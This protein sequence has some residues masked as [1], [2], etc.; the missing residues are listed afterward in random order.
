M[1]EI[2]II[3]HSNGSVENVAEGGQFEG[4][5]LREGNKQSELIIPHIELEESSSADDLQAWQFNLL[6]VD[7][8]Y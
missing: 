1:T 2:V 8:T 6:G 3:E 4:L 7:M 5:H